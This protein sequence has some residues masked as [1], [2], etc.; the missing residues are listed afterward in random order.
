MPSTNLLHADVR[1]ESSFQLRQSGTTWQTIADQLGFRNWQQARHAACAWARHTEQPEPGTGSRTNNAAARPNMGTTRFG[2]EIEFRRAGR[3]VP[4]AEIVAALAN[5]GIAC[6]SPGY[7]HEVMDAWKI[8]PDGST[9]LELVSP[10]LSGPEGIRQISTVTRVLRSLGCRVGRSEGLH[11]H[12]EVRPMTPSARMRLVRLYTDR[13]SAIDSLV[14]VSRRN[15][16][17]CQHLPNLGNREGTVQYALDA[18]AGR[19]IPEYHGMRYRTVNVCSFPRYGTL[20]FRQHHGTL[21]GR[22]IA[23]WVR[24]L[25]ALVA[26][27]NAATNE[28]RIPTDFNGFVGYLVDNAY[29]SQS[30]ADRLSARSA[31]YGA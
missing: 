29:L 27:A 20:E 10:P 8:V 16:Y 25:L 30:D 7:T 4:E 23:E 11:V 24:F 9:D 5:E 15:A 2:V 22:K 13:Q 31:R 6:Y 26:C 28:P 14:P 21:D 18:M 1:A 12:V 19:V 3:Y 17:Y